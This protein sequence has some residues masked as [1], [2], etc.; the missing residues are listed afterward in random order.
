MI[1]VMEKFVKSTGN[2]AD[3]DCRI[4]ALK[5]LE[6]SSEIGDDDEEKRQTMI[7]PIK[8]GPTDKELVDSAIKMVEYQYERAGV[9]EKED[10]RVNEKAFREYLQNYHSKLVAKRNSAVTTQPDGDE[11]DMLDID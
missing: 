7:K 3:N 10:L 11:S 9:A 4:M 8:K 6:I 1:G 2:G 5:D